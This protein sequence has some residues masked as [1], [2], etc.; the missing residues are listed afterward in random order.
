LVMCT[1][2]SFDEQAASTQVRV[3]TANRF[4]TCF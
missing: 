3:K 4:I 1:P 2:L